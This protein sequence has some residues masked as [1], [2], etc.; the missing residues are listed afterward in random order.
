MDTADL[1]DQPALYRQWKWRV[2]LSFCAFYSMC[3]LGRF[4]F[5]LI[6]TAI[7]ADLGITRADTG[8][9][10]SWMFWGFAAGGIF[11]GRIAERIGYRVVLLY[12]AAGVGV[13]NH[14]ASYAGSVNGLLFAWALAGFFG[15]ATWA[16]G[17][18][19]IAQWWPRR[20][21]GRAV[22]AASAAAG[23]AM[24][25][26]WLVSP[27]VAAEWGWRAAMR[28]PPL[29]VSLM[30]V[31]L[32]FIARDRPGDLNLPE[33]VESEAVSREAEEVP[34]EAVRGAAAIFHVLSNWRFFV[35]C[36]VRGLDVLV[37]YGV[38]AWAP[39]YYTQV[40]GF[41]LKAMALVTFAYPV[42]IMLG[43]LC[44]GYISDRLFKSNRSRVIMLAGFLSSMAIGGI[45]LSPA[46]NIPLAAGLLFLVGFT[47]NMAPLPAL[48]ID[49]VGRRLVGTGTGLLS[50]HGYI[51]GAMQAWLFGLLSMVAGGWTLIFGAMALARL[52]SVGVIWRVR[53]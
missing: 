32:Y 1:E 40:G 38:V 30:G 20:E 21:R 22:G 28:W 33:Y 46:D 3:Y 8:W 53:A 10:N 47:T 44:G 14:I 12:G 39:V 7:I 48:A 16:P 45:A 29:L 19:L 52:I 24:L 27:W 37:R 26:T 51:Y 9:I 41:D 43:P 11:H 34:E 13:F 35:A 5:S 49:L 4:N 42:G 17:L 18:G 25:I 36:H 2:L 23:L 50:V 15:A 31:G 6:Q